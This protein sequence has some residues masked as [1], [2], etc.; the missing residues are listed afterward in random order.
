MISGCRDLQGELGH[1]L[2]RLDQRVVGELVGDVVASRDDHP[3]QRVV[4]DA[5][6]DEIGRGVTT[7]GRSSTCWTSSRAADG[8]TRRAAR[9]AASTPTARRISTTERII[10]PR[11][12]L[13]RGAELAEQLEAGMGPPVEHPSRAAVTHLDQPGL[14]EP[15]HRLADRVPVDPELLGEPTFPRKWRA[16]RESRRRGS[17]RAA[18]GRRR[19]RPQ[20]ARPA[21]RRPGSERVTRW[22]SRRSG[23]QPGPCVRWADRSRHLVA[24]RR[25][26]RSRRTHGTRRAP[27]C[28]S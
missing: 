2:Q 25:R 17:R 13:D 4:R 21:R 1:P 26:P 22:R 6:L 11:R 8:S 27:G 18:G 3:P 16:G 28:T 15:A 7:A 10:V 19:R 14:L 5:E 24:R 12:D 23:V 20:P 9:R